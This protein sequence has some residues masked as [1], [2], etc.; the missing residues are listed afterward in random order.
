LAA[1][2][3]GLAE[4]RMLGWMREMAEEVHIQWDQ[5]LL[6]LKA[7]QRLGSAEPAILL[8][9]L[10]SKRQH[11]WMP[12][13]ELKHRDCHLTAHEYKALTSWLESAKE[14][15]LD[16]EMPLTTKDNGEQLATPAFQ[17][18]TNKRLTLPV[19]TT[20]SPALSGQIRSSQVTVA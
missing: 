19:H 1:T 15:E 17:E 8:T 9:A 12:V 7:C 16:T 18:T 10:F 3:Q 5:A 4:E 13:E 14:Q 6:C 20:T 11:Q 2:A